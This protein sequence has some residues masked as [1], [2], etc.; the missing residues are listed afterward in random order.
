MKRAFF[1]LSLLIVFSLCF[2]AYAQDSEYSR[3][4]G[5]RKYFGRDYIVRNPKETLSQPCDIPL[6]KLDFTQQECFG[7]TEDQKISFFENTYHPRLA[8]HADTIHVVWYEWPEE[9]F[10]KRSTDGGET[11]GDSIVLSIVD[12]VSSVDPDIAVEGRNVYVVWED[13]TWMDSGGIYFRKSTN[14]GATWHSRIPIALR[15]V[16]NYDYYRPRIAVKENEIYVCYGKN[17]DLETFF[18][19]KKSTDYGETWGQEVLISERSPAGKPAEMVKNQAG[20]HVAWENSNE[21]YYNKSTDWG[22]QWGADIL[23]SEADGIYSQWAFIGADDLGGVYV[24]WFDYKYSPYG[25]TGDIFLRRSTDNGIT[26]DSIISLTDNHLCKESDVCA[27]T[28]SVDVVWHDE[29]HYRNVELYHRRSIDLGFSWQEEDRLTDALYGSWDPRITKDNSKLY[30]VWTDDRNEPEP[31]STY[32]KKG[33]GYTPGDVNGDRIVNSGDIVFLI[34]YLFVAGPSP[35]I[36]ESGDANSDGL[37]N[38]ADVAYLINFLF[39]GGP[40]PVDCQGAVN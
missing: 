32:F 1:T 39:I 40:S 11:W 10:Y 5:D 37:I 26:W 3:I 13:W 23:I 7:W 15:G 20:L 4:V 29:R 19:F 24:T 18:C 36:F 28:F 16:D 27:D 17:L 31:Q 35:I 2:F 9:V 22:H 12:N 6:A 33:Y 14:E 21:I 8:A 38:S 30:M 34:N 25:W